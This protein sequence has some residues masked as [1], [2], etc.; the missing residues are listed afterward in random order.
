MATREEAIAELRRR[1][2]IAELQRRG[3]S[4]APA[5]TSGANQ[6]INL[7]LS[8]AQG[9]SL[10]VGPKAMSAI[11]A[12]MAYPV[13]AGLKAATGQEIPSWQDL[14]NIPVSDIQGRISQS[15]ED[16]PFLSGI[17]ELGGGIKT[18]AN[19]AGTKAAQAVGNWTKASG[20]GIS[21][22]ML[23]AGKKGLVGGLAGEAGYRVY[24]AATAPS[25]E[26]ASKL[27]AP[28][29]TPGGMLGAALPIAG[30]VAG[31]VAKIASSAL[32]QKV[33]PAAEETV[34]VLTS[35]AQK[36]KIPLSVDD[37]A[38]SELYKR[39]IAQGEKLPFSG[40]KK[41]AAEK[42]VAINRAVSRTLGKEADKITPEYLLDVKKTLGNDFESFT[43]GKEFVA[44]SGFYSKVDEIVNK[45]SRGDYGEAGQKFVDQ[46]KTRI[47]SLADENG[48]IKGDRLDKLRREFA[49]TERNQGASDVGRLAGDFEDTVVD[50]ISSSD[51]KIAKAITDAKYKY[52]NYKTVIGIAKKEQATGDINPVLLSNRVSAK[53]GEDA[54]ATGQA[55][56]LGEIARIGQSLRMPGTS[57]TAEN[58]IA[59]LLLTGGAAGAGATVGLPG[60][61]AL[62]AG[63]VGNRLLQSYNRNPQSVQNL[64]LQNQTAIPFFGPTMQNPAVSSGILGSYLGGR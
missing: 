43:K 16:N 63:L 39:M 40:A 50:I 11:G 41:S 28:G 58:L 57:G 25:G 33:D 61:A 45:A 5:E 19:I 17:A 9:R 13:V 10:G 30:A 15:R 44:D 48:K 21:N 42:Q 22:A 20:P 46:Y 6:A 54:F 36:H 60:V 59:N 18:G 55:G 35:L 26:E 53:F 7:G 32:A 3:V 2:A 24:D 8:Y 56:D 49:E 27:L 37:L 62:G 4:S 1:E 31:P 64:M 34:K 52:K 38:G 14:Y 23:S 12:T 29:V 51:P 47:L